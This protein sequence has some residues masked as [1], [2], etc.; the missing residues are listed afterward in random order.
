MTPEVTAWP[1]RLL[2]TA[3]VIGVIVLA[4][5]GMWRGWR[6][7]SERESAELAALAEVPTSLSP[8][9]VEVSG[10][11]VGTVRR[12]DWMVRVLAHG[13]GAPGSAVASVHPEG[14]LFD[15]DGA[16]ALFIPASAMTGVQTGNG[17]A[18]T[19]RE[20]DGIAVIGWTWGGI[21]LDSGFRSPDATA[22]HAFISA[23]SALLVDQEGQPA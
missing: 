8:A 1:E 3:A 23:A 9:Q 5:W 7:R 15:R 4:A 10:S 22:Q 13:L 20:R 2:L 6:R 17:L 14:V 21:E 16:A 18:G 19:V 11:Y 12:G